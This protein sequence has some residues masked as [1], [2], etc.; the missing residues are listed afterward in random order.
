MIIDF[1]LQ[2]LDVILGHFGY[3]HSGPSTPPAAS[4]RAYLKAASTSR[5]K[6]SPRKI[7][8]MDVIPYSSSGMLR[9]ALGGWTNIIF[10]ELAFG[11]LLGFFAIELHHRVCVR[12]APGHHQNG[13]Q[14]P[15]TT[16]FRYDAFIIRSPFLPICLWNGFDQERSL[17]PLPCVAVLYLFRSE[18]SMETMPVI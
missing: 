6:G 13:Q 3:L 10:M 5:L 4:Y 11:E 7:C 16:I 17:N 8:R 15:P 9:P 14:Q 1:S 2:H 18:F 12:S